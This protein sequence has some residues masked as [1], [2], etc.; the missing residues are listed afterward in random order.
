MTTSPRTWAAQPSRRSCG[1]ALELAV[2]RLDRA[3]R[4]QVVGRGG[5]PVLGELADALLDL[6]AAA[7][8]AAAADRVDVDAEPAGGVEHGRARRRTG[9][10]GP[11]G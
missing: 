9:R 8:P 11:T 2:L 10:A 5:D 4:G 7:D 1:E 3:E 6:A